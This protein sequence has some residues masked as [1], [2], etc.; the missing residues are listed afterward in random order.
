MVGVVLVVAF[1]LRGQGTALPAPE[2]P[3]PVPSA[4]VPSPSPLRVFFGVGT[5]QTDPPMDE[6]PTPAPT[7]A[8]TTSPSAAPAE[9]KRPKPGPAGE[10]SQP[11][12]RSG[13]I[14]VG[15]YATWYDSP[16]SLGAAAGPTLRR[17][18]GKGWRGNRVLVCHAT[19]CVEVRLIDWCACG[20][21]HGVPTVLD[22]TAGAFR[23]L[24]P[25]SRGVIRVQ[26]EGF[27]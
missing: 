3:D 5:L 22:L 14:R 2:A 13:T 25:L 10:H 16:V 15:G 12:R 27:R 17:A 18:L 20:K 1:A 7:K 6:L 9:A 4:V 26:V 21:R 24:A 23:Y 11:E 8:P 19:R